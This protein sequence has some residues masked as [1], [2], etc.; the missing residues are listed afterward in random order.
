MINY[1]LQNFKSQKIRFLLSIGGIGLCVI[2]M[3]FLLATYNGVKAGSLEYIAQNESD[4]WVLQKNSTNILRC[5][6]VLVSRHYKMLNTVSGIKSISPVLLILTSIEQED[7]K[8]TVYLCGYNPKKNKGGPPSI[9]EGRHIRTDSEIVLDKAFASKYDYQVNENIQIQNDTLTIVGLSDGTNAFV[10]QYAFVTLKKAKSFIGIPIVTCFLI[11]IDDNANLS[12]LANSIKH[13]L[14]D[15]EV[16][17][18]AQFLK[19]N[20]K[21]MQAGFL[22]FIF[23]IVGISAVVLTVILSLLLS[24]TIL[25]RRKDFAVMK[26]LG[27]RGIFL[28]KLIFQQSFFLSSFG[29]LIAL[30]LYTPLKIFVEQLSPEISMQ[31]SL[32][33]FLITSLATIAIS[34]LSSFISLQRLRKIYP[35]EVFHESVS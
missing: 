12:H 33:Q 11:D 21:E 18:H 30:L 22:P 16:M 35:L 20:L 34:I 2:L 25:E 7:K 3:L 14:P 31:S 17:N 10:I 8:A 4:L 15:V 6:S 32:E 19:N 27:A 23:T 1:T 13:R 9:I 26:I 29:I 5:T 28:S 24:I